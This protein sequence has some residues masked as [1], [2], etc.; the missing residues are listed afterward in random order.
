MIVDM[1]KILVILKNILN[2]NIERKLFQFHKESVEEKNQSLLKFYKE[3]IVYY[4][5]SSIS[6]SVDYEGYQYSTS[7]LLCS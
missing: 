2:E 3:I 7:S 5:A 4:N 1:T 6:L